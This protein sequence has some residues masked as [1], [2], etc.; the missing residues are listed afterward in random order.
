MS[1]LYETDILDWSE[2]Q[3]ALLRRVAAGD[4]TNHEVPDWDNII[5]EIE[6]AG[7]S[8]LRACESLLVQ[9]L[10]HELEISTWPQS[11]D[12]PHWRAEAREF[13][14]DAVRAFSPSMRQRIDMT[15]LYTDAL[16]RLP[17]SIDGQAPLPV[18]TECPLTLDEMLK[19]QS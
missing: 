17:E 10:L 11:R 16:D 8:E 4:R 2:R 5:E 12:V 3:A 7:R 18:P 14:R 15:A 1:D 13:R 9:A 19:V 6:S